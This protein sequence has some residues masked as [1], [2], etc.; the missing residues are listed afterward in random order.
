MTPDTVFVAV[1]IF[2]VGYLYSLHRSVLSLSCGKTLFTIPNTSP[3]CSIM[4]WTAARK[5]NKQ[6][7]LWGKP[8]VVLFH[9]AF[10][11]SVPPGAMIRIVVWL[12]KLHWA[13]KSLAFSHADQVFFDHVKNTLIVRVC[14]FVLAWKQHVWL[15]HHQLLIYYKWVLVACVV[16]YI[17]GLVVEF[18][19]TLHGISNLCIVMFRFRIVKSLSVAHVGS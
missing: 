10:Q 14:L 18:Y 4:G 6:L 16:Q 3:N 12:S 15:V 2:H 17:R 13:L 5:T 8:L 9:K 1:C 7:R 11:C 19:C